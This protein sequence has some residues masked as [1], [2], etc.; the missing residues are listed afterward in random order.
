ME[1]WL[2]LFIFKPTN[3]LLGFISSDLAVTVQKSNSP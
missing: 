3:E 1:E 2:I